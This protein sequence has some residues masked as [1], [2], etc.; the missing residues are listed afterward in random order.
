[1]LDDSEN[2]YNEEETRRTSIR[3]FALRIQ[4]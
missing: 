4:K 1:V 3:I 2:E